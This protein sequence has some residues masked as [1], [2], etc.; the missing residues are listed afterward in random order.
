MSIHENAEIRNYLCDLKHCP[1]DA[2]EGEDTNIDLLEQ[3]TVTGCNIERNQCIWVDEHRDEV[4][5]VV[6]DV[7]GK[8]VL[9]GSQMSIS[10]CKTLQRA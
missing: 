2:T 9:R 4:D 5:S 8:E 6:H 7:A 3:M 1:G 10:T